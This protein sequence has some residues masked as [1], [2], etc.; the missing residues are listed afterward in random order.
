MEIVDDGKISNGKLLEHKKR[1]CI[2]GLIRV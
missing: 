1:T 2:V